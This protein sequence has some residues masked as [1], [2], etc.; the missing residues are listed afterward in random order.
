MY[1]Q[2]TLNMETEFVPDIL[3]SDNFGCCNLYRECSLAGKCVRNDERSLCCSYRKHLEQ[4][5]IFYSPA[6]PNFDG[7]Y[8]ETLCKT[9]ESLDDKEGFWQLVDYFVREKRMAINLFCLSNDRIKQVIAAT[10]ELDIFTLSCDVSEYTNNALISELR[11]IITDVGLGI[12]KSIKKNRK[13]SITEAFNKYDVL[14]DALF[15]KYMFIT[16]NS[17]KQIYLDEFFRKYYNNNSIK[18]DLADIRRTQSED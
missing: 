10:K 17:S 3:K 9:Y 11:K 7:G 15:Q 5:E 1:E 2:M 18:T 14:S 12:E 4:G 8:F 16:S 6:S 13:D